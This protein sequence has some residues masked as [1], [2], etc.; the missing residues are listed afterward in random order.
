MGSAVS[1]LSVVIITLAVL[2]GAAFLLFGLE[3][4]ANPPDF[5]RSFLSLD[6][7]TRAEAEEKYTTKM[8]DKYC[9]DDNLKKAGKTMPA[10]PAAETA[11]STGA[12]KS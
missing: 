6:P 11:P 5:V 9:T 3:V 12:A 1:T 4:R 2:V 8:I 7:K 10:A